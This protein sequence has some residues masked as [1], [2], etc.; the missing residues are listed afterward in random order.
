MKNK[1]GYESAK[2]NGLQ[3][4]SK[5]NLGGK[6]GNRYV[7]LFE[8]VNT[9]V[10]LLLLNTPIILMIIILFTYADYNY[11]LLYIILFSYV[12]P[13]VLFQCKFYISKFYLFNYVADHRK[14]NYVMCLS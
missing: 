9:T 3:P 5:I 4:G 11:L 1:L 14:S 6:W 10:K 13:Q 12:N 8:I 7:C 2:V